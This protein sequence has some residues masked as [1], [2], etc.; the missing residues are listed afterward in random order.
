[1]DFFAQNLLKWFEKKGRKNLPWQQHGSDYHTWLS[2]IM[3]QQTQVKTVITYFQRFIIRFPTIFDLANAS[4]DEVLNLWTGLGYYARAR[5]LH[6][7][8]QII[9]QQ[10]Q[11]KFPQDLEQL[12]ALPGIGRSTAAAILSLAFHQPATILDGNVKRVLSRFHA[13]SGWQK[14]VEQTLWTLAKQHTPNHS[15]AAYTQA[16]MDLGA[17]ICTPKQPL[18]SECPVKTKCKAHQ[19]KKELAFPEK[20]PK[21]QLPTKQIQFVIL[22]NNQKRVLLEKRPPVGIWGGLWSFPECDLEQDLT[23]WCQE[24][25]GLSIAEIQSLPQIKHNFSHYHL[26]IHPKLIA[27][28][29]S[30]NSLRESAPY[31]WHSLD[32]YLKLG[33]ATPVKRLLSYLHSNKSRK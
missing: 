2:E 21:K 25:F 14:S 5:N 4:I 29:Q 22:K 6:K 33:L 7:T 31:Q 24:K 8:A 15:N 17:T 18:C 27:I 13:V 9:A 26:E 11:G 12:V 32:E 10:Y 28:T 23:N 1:M 19:L 3:L 30:N 16:I 20:K